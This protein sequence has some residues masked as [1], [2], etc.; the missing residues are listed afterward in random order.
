M[1][2]HSAFSQGDL[3]QRLSSPSQGARGRYEEFGE[4]SNGQSPM[5]DTQ[6]RWY[7]SSLDDVSQYPL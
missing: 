5:L 4:V 7:F 2:Q 6:I 3:R 1:S